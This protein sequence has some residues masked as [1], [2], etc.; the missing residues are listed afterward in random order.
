MAAASATA[1]LVQKA[2][3]AAAAGDVASLTRQVEESRAVMEEKDARITKLERVRLTKDD[4]DKL[5]NM[6]HNARNVAAENVKLNERVAELTGV[7]KTLGEKLRPYA[8]RVHELEKEHNAVRAAV[9]EAGISTGDGKNLGDAIL[10]LAE[11]SAGTDASMMSSFSGGEAAAVAAAVAGSERH[12]AQLQEAKAALRKQES[13]LLGVQE[14][15]RAGVVRFRELEAREATVRER[16]EQT[17]SDTR[18]KLKMQEKDHERQLRFLQVGIGAWIEFF[19][20]FARKEG[21][22]DR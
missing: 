20:F 9:E 1:E 11:R 6:K 16:L 4:V 13:E 18:Q 17:E 10:E 19:F 2:E 15:M 7:K 12:Y 21:R 14:K 3:A 22:C 5:R 8:L